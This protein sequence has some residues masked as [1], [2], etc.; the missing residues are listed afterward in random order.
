MVGAAFCREGGL[1]GRT[2]HS[3]LSGRL[4]GRMPL[5][6]RCKKIAP[7][8]GRNEKPESMH[9]RSA[10][11]EAIQRHDLRPRGNEVLDELRIA[12]VGRIDFGDGPQF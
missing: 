5:P 6:R 8:R 1:K 2:D 11:I 12:I 4:R 10:E 7:L 3:G 9:G